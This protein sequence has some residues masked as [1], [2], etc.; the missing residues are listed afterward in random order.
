MFVDTITTP[1]IGDPLAALELLSQRCDAA[2]ITADIQ[3]LRRELA[4]STSPFPQVSRCA[5]RLCARLHHHLG[6][7]RSALGRPD[8]ENLERCNAL[9]VARVLAHAIV[10]LHSQNLRRA[11]DELIHWLTTERMKFLMA[12]RVDAVLSLRDSEPDAI[13]RY[14]L[15]HFARRVF[16]GVDRSLAQISEHL[17]DELAAVLVDLGDVVP[18]D[19]LA[20]FELSLGHAYPIATDEASVIARL[21]QGSR[22][23]INRALADHEEARYALAGRLIELLDSAHASLQLAADVAD[24]LTAAGPDAMAREHARLAAWTSDLTDIVANLG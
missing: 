16:A 23:V 8:H 6:E 21:E 14:H 22:A 9:T 1:A 19:A 12:T 13:V 24:E 18:F 10:E 2:A 4:R 5:L 3:A 7:R 15:E 11:P 20:S 17:L